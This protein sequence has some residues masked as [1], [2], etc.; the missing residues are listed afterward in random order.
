LN[1]IDRFV[2]LSLPL[3]LP[4]LC[5][6]LKW[7]C[8]S[9]IPLLVSY[10]ICAF[11]FYRLLFLTFGH[12]SM[13]MWPLQIC[14]DML[15]LRLVMFG[16]HRNFL[17][18]SF[19]CFLHN[20]HNHIY[21]IYTVCIQYI[22]D[23]ILVRLKSVIATS[24]R[25]VAYRFNSHNNNNIIIIIIVH[26]HHDHHHHRSA[27]IVR[28]RSLY[29]CMFLSWLYTSLTTTALEENIEDAQECPDPKQSHMN[30]IPNHT[31]EDDEH[32]NNP[33]RYNNN[34]TTNTYEI[35]YF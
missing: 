24:T 25:Y 27:T 5:V 15:S 10:Y 8:L 13:D 22:K 31:A 6:S 11:G 34:N 21:I 7:V 17:Q 33:S 18:T 3:S 14:S 29:A 30:S 9:G 16:R 19:H 28:F 1:H 2:Y 4:L 32:G 26:H 12:S 20:L 35:L 23:R